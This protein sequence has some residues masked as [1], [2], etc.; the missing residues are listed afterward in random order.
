MAEN[1]RSEVETFMQGLI[2]RN[3]GEAEFHQA[4]REVVE[5]LMP[6]V[7]NQRKYHEAR[8]LERLTE[9]DRT[10]I[11]RVDWEDDHGN[12]RSNRAWRVQFNNAIGPYKGGLRFHPS[13]N[14]SVFKFLGFEQILK[15]R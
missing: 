1:V 11:F 5:S 8:I 9:P 10:V 7:L 4:V 15:T 6:F 3:P 13:V 14:L 2:R 12:I